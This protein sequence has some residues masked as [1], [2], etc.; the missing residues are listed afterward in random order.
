MSDISKNIRE[1]L[2]NEFR[3]ADLGLK[4]AIS[5]RR[6]DTAKI[7]FETSDGNFIESVLIFA[8]DS[9]RGDQGSRITLC[10]SSQAGCPLS[11]SFCA[12]GRAVFKRNLDTSEI[13]S[14][15]LFAEEYILKISR[16]PGTSG[17]N[18]SNIVFMGMGEPLLNYENVIKSID[19]LNYSGG[20]N[21]G[22]RHFTIST[23]GIVPQ[24]NELKNE[25]H[26]VRLAVSLNSAIQDK[27]ASLMP[28]SKKYPL[29]DLMKALRDY[30]DSTGRRIT[31]E[32]VLLDTIN[33]TDHDADALK[34]MLSGLH[35]NLNLIAFNPA[36]GLPFSRPSERSIVKFMELLTARR[37]PFVLRKSMGDEISA[38]CGQLGQSHYFERLFR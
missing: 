16:Q 10:I 29:P 28:V 2:N 27:R 32:Y 11:C 8:D 5:D 20:Y 26:Q 1:E 13:I 25:K 14:Q 17:R 24:I 21:L 15:V 23:A 38:A 31:F 22:S 6:S 37:I 18:I 30:Q 19:I 33:D 34:D 4:D 9:F 12:T 36:E 3:I 7:L 35:F